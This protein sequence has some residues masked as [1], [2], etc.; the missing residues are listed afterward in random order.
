MNQQQS[1]RKEILRLVQT[2]NNSAC[3]DTRR[4]S[5]FYNMPETEVRRVLTR[6]ADERVIQLSGWDGRSLRPYRE[7]A[8]AEEFVNSK[9]GEGHVHVEIEPMAKA[10]CA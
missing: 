10:T 8:T 2:R 7:W 6:L 3:I 4:L 5:M 9:E 1:I